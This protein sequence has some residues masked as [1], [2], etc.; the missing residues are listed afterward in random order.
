MG[1]IFTIKVKIKESQLIISKVTKDDSG[2]WECRAENS[3]GSISHSFDVHV[4]N[5]SLFFLVSL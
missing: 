1:L 3:M 2:L 5:V 4:Q